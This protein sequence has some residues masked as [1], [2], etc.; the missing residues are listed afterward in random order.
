[1][2][3]PMKKKPD[4]GVLLGMG[5]KR[6]PEQ[7]PPD[8]GGGKAPQADPEPDPL[9]PN[10]PAEGADEGDLTPEMLD[11]SGSAEH[12]ESCKHYTAPST[13][14]RWTQPVEATGHCEGFQAGGMDDMGGG[15]QMPA[16]GGEAESQPAA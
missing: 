5:P 3:F 13:C 6:A 4:F 14:D 7:G 2:A 11:Y 9:D 15:D 8:F 16:Q 12:C 1:M 10:E